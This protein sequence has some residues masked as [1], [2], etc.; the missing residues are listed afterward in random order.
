[1][2]YQEEEEGGERDGEERELPHILYPSVLVF[3]SFVNVECPI[4]MNMWGGKDHVF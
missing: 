3:R 1:M 2:R 4:Y